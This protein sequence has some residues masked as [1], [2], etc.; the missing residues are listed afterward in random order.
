MTTLNTVVGTLW[1]FWQ[2]STIICKM[3]R[4]IDPRQ[5]ETHQ[6]VS[7]YHMICKHHHQQQ[8]NKIKDFKFERFLG[9]FLFRK[10]TEW[11][12][13]YSEPCQTSKMERFAKTVGG[14]YFSQNTPS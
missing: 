2:S 8:P 14:N 10:S 6:T 1:N 9:K 7:E 12:E 4:G 5:L 13:A 3:I 11:P